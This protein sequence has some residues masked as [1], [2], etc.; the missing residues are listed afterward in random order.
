MPWS[1]IVAVPAGIVSGLIVDGIVRAVAK[2]A[3]ASDDVTKV[4]GELANGLTSAAVNGAVSTA[5]LDPVT[6]AASPLTGLGSVALGTTLY[7]PDG[8]FAPF[9]KELVR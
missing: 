1:S 8:P 4:L 2:E 6:A 3:G 9:V 5:M 7:D